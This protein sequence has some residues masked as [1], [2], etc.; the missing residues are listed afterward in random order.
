MKGKEVF[1]GVGPSCC[2]GPIGE[3]GEDKGK[4]G[5]WR[6][7]W[8]KEQGE[9]SQMGEG[10]SCLWMPHLRLQLEPPQS[11]NKHEINKFRHTSI[12]N[13]SGE[14]LPNNAQSVLKKGTGKS[15]LRQK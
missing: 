11:F 15:Y 4:V 12:I 9:L 3:M 8:V 6:C 14:K 1:G 2:S 7:Y 13:L 5:K 10:L